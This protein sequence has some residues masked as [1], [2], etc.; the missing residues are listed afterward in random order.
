MRLA[1]EQLL[2]A[3]SLDGQVERGRAPVQALHEPQHLLDPDTGRKATSRTR[4]EHCADPTL[5][6]G[7]TRARA[8]YL[9]GPGIRTEQAEEQ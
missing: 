1:T 4:L 9:D 2:D 6:D 3:R 7:A 5:S 8:E